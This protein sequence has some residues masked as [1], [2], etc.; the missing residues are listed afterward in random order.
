MD[1]KL[2]FTIIAKQIQE[3]YKTRHEA[4][5]YHAPAVTFEP[6]QKIIEIKLVASEEPRNKVL[7]LRH[8]TQALQNLKLV[9]RHSD[10][11]EKAGYIWHDNNTLLVNTEKIF[12]P[13]RME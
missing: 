9:I 5:S 8:L 4:Y 7:V 10:D 13:K 6:N 11:P 1:E 2:D 3:H 12:R